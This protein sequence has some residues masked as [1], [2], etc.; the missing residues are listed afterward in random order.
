MKNILQNTLLVLAS[1][2]ILP[3][4]LEAGMR[5]YTGNYS[6]ENAL[7]NHLRISM[8]RYPTKYDEQLGWLSKEGIS[9][10][11]SSSMRITTL[12]GGIR[13]NGNDA[14]RQNAPGQRPILAVGDSYTFGYEVRDEET[15]P[16]ILESL[17]G[18]QVI[19]GGGFA[20]GMDQSLLRARQL[21]DRYQ[22]DTLIYSFIPNDIWRN[23]ISARSGVSKP[24]FDIQDSALVL[25][26]TPVPPPALTDFGD[27]G[28]RKYLGYSV[29]VHYF[30]M[31]SKFAM[32]WV[33]G[34]QWKDVKVHDDAKGEEIACLIIREL[35]EIAA[36]R[37]IVVYLL[38][39][40]G[41]HVG[42]PY[43][44]NS[45]RA[46]KCAAPEN[47]FVIDLYDPLLKIKNRDR[48]EFR[49]L[50]T[51]GKQH[52]MTFQGNSIVARILNDTISRVPPAGE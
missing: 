47:L 32:W 18:R 1:L 35:D 34:E 9:G 46:I 19:N 22:P 36:T 15:W 49:S 17:T 23:Q 43:T 11:E 42:S 7:E 8:A 52:H 51:K 10:D 25:K 20:Y 41:K 38:A 40:Y 24:Y 33:R 6:F 14:I 5:L 13:S 26:N 28:A 31:R 12:E 3:V 21:I 2:L 16:A 44:Q 4:M 45:R 50:F 30:M 29:F 39:Q 48:A 37:N 27:P